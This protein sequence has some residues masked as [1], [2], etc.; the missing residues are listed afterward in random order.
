MREQYLEARSTLVNNLHEELIGP[1]SGEFLDA[2]GSPCSIPNKECEVIT[3]LPER[4]YYIGVLYPQRNQ[5]KQDNDDS[6]EES[7]LPCGDE[8]V[9]S[10]PSIDDSERSTPMIGPDISDESIDEVIALSTQDRPSS[11]GISFSV[12][13][14]LDQ[15][16]VTFEF[17]TYRPT[18]PVDC[19]V[20][21]TPSEVANGIISMP[22]FSQFVYLE[23]GYLRLKMPMASYDVTS[24]W[25]ANEY[26][27]PELKSALYKLAAQNKKGTGFKREPHRVTLTLT[28]NGIQAPA[29]DGVSFASACAIKNKAT[30]NRWIIT[31][32]LFN[33]GIGHFNGTN[34]L[35]QPV[36]TVE[37]VN[38]PN[39]NFVQYVDHMDASTDEEEKSLALLYR[40]KHRFASGHGAAVKWE[41][42]STGSYVQ[43]DLMPLCEVP[44][45]DFDYAFSRG[46]SKKAL[47][48]KYLSDLS[49]ATSLERVEAIKELVTA[50]DC[51]IADLRKQTIPAEMEATAQKHIS[52]CQM[53]S[54]RMKK[55]LHCLENDPLAMRAFEL[56]NRAM[57]MQMIH[58]KRVSDVPEDEDSTS[59]NYTP[60]NYSNADIEFTTFIWRPFQ[61]AFL[62]M[63]ISGLIETTVASHGDNST[64]DRDIVDIIWF[65]TGGGK[66]EAYLAVTAFIIFYRR[67]KYPSAADGTAIL[68]RYTLR[69]LTSQ[70]FA[71]ASTLI[72]ACE[73]IRKELKKNDRSVNPGWQ[74]PISIGLWIG[75]DHTPNKT[76]SS[77]QGDDKSAEYYVKKLTDAGNGRNDIAYRNEKYNH[78]QVLAC[79]WCGAS[80]VPVNVQSGA[81]EKW[82]YRM[83]GGHFQL[84]CVRP[85]CPFE[86]QLPIQVVDDELYESPPTLLFATVDKFA[87]MAWN[88]KIGA[89]FAVGSSNRAPELIIQDELHLISGPLGSVVGL[90]ESAI[91]AL[92][93]AKGVKPKIIA[94]TA[95]IR[96]AA[97]Q[98][99][100]LYNRPIQQFPPPGLDNADSFFAKEAN[101]TEKPGRLYVGVFPSGKT[102]AMLETRV[103]STLLQRVHMLALPD[104]VKDKYWTL[105]GYFN[106]LRDLGKCSGLVDDDIKDF[107]KRM[108]RRISSDGHVRPISIANELTSRVPTTVL[109]KRLKQLE[110]VEYSQENQE[111]HQFAINVLLATNM[112][113]VGVDVDR[114]NL[115]TVIGQPKLTSEYIQAT[116]RVGRKYPGLVFTLYDATKSRDRSHYEQFGA[117]HE[118]FY[119]YVEPTSV[120][121]F[122]QPALDRALHAVMISL[123]RNMDAAL[124]QEADA[125][126][127]RMCNETLCRAKK[128]IVE[129]IQEIYSCSE[130]DTRTEM[131]AITQQIDDFFAEWAN[132][133]EGLHSADKLLYGLSCIMRTP[134]A[135]E[136]ILLRPF[137]KWIP[138]KDIARETLTSMRNVDQSIS[139]RMVIWEEECHEET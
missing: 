127:L 69:L 103:M 27:L 111:K 135:N 58:R 79:P 7:S 39:I 55:G 78:F 47:S 129:R 116:S 12:D 4:R 59:V 91:D 97:E 136:H 56:A 64:S 112:I 23:A 49:P 121:P 110:K 20:P 25:K 53:A 36:I 104:K 134:G 13:Q 30:D 95:T 84:Q 62:L 119:R 28:T 102:K 98:C 122:S 60:V 66:T 15:I 44:Q 87:M 123:I 22:P 99:R 130:E 9:D 139:G 21:Y 65:P 138:N 83:S 29:L 14:D 113:S 94:S 46:V 132:Y 26:Q 45:M 8:D 75:G 88:E 120:T 90:Y 72:C 86:K 105:V 38:N 5:M 1:G 128:Q 76:K 16:A 125:K 37:S 124:A 81:R 126:K 34:S 74:N 17:A 40:N 131:E 18:L 77:H 52:V 137:G 61:A 32:M 85:R 100:Y 96:R 92:C 67:M 43:T 82:G 107:M 50:Y 114:L 117:Y 89:F 35:F 63:S 70:Q 10:S 11:I 115:M 80:L 33:T 54:D 106:N 73:Q 57:F 109:V 48:L 93:S 133:A 101:T 42:S 41:I 2:A 19:M 31:I 68:M 3:D 108:C 71:R 24:N 118:S 51:W 6:Q